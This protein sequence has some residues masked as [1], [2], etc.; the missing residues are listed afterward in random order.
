MARGEKNKIVTYYRPC[1]YTPQSLGGG[2][3]SSV[4]L[5]EPTTVG[6]FWVERK[7]TWI[8]IPLWEDR[9]NVCYFAQDSRKST[10]SEISTHP[11]LLCLMS[12]GHKTRYQYCLPSF[13][14]DWWN[15]YRWSDRGTSDNTEGKLINIFI[16]LM[17]QVGFVR[18]MT[19][20]CPGVYIGV[21]S[22]YIK[23]SPEK[24]KRHIT[25][26]DKIQQNAQSFYIAH[27]L[28][29]SFIHSLVHSF[30]PITH[31]T[32]HAS[33]MHHPL[34]HTMHH[35]FITLPNASY[36]ASPIRHT[37]CISTHHTSKTLYTTNNT[38]T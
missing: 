32:T 21:Y 36:H 38:D 1:K 2:G 23:I 16:Y 7:L 25:N 6:S 27:T 22:S 33:P 35:P 10:R 18:K 8:W 13:L 30:I 31:H 34:H 37:A 12:R 9:K 11:R 4:K 20:A 28:I 15:M 29:Y 3:V 24:I 14:C 19:N 17:L 26:T 5:M